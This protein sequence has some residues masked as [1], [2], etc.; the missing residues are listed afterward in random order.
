[1]KDE[2]AEVILNSSTIHLPSICD[3]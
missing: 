1:V 2:A 3:R